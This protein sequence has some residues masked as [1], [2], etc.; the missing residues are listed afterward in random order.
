[1]YVV[2]ETSCGSSRPVAIRKTAIAA[3][4]RCNELARERMGQRHEGEIEVLD[5]GAV[6]RPETV[7]FTAIEVED[8]ADI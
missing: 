7:V 3:A 4:T 6:Y 5:M 2:M 1:M 8:V